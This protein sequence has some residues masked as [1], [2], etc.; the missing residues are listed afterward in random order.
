M[1]PRQPF[2]KAEV[3]A[4][5]AGWGCN[6]GPAALAFAAQT[7]LDAAH[8]AI[9]GFDKKQYTNPTMMQTALDTLGVPFDKIG[10]LTADNMVFDG[11]S[12]VRI[13]FTGPWDGKPRW[14]ST[15]T[16][17]IAT[18]KADDGM[19]AAFDINGGCRPF[20]NWHDNILPLL[21]KSKKLRDGGWRPVNIW[22]MGGGTCG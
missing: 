1:N 9:P 13:Q 12:L 21:V 6:C 22:R 8:H 7:T 17:W 4:A 15:H 3:D 18:W 2:T 20:R 14:A 16:H 10:P 5:I 19:P 11:L